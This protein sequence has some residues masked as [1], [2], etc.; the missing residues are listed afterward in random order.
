M[1]MMTIKD[2]NDLTSIANCLDAKGL[3]KE[4]DLLD[5]VMLKISG[6]LDALK[7]FLDND[8]KDTGDDKEAAWAAFEDEWAEIEAE[9]AE[10]T[11]TPLSAEEK[12][13]I[14]EKAL[15][16]HGRP[17]ALEDKPDEPESE[18]ARPAQLRDLLDERFPLDERKRLANM[19]LKDYQHNYYISDIGM[20][21]GYEYA[22]I[23]G[24]TPINTATGATYHTP[25]WSGKKEWRAG[26][27]FVNFGDVSEIDLE[28]QLLTVISDL[29]GIN[30]IVL[31]TG[32]RTKSLPNVIH[33][34][35][36]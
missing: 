1:N 6:R 35:T 30:D 23:S 29:P 28:E 2:V 36:N 3:T 20:K 15:A 12:A 9:V 33:P 17:S 11:K 31:S 26:D 8:G 27:R 18:T 14:R 21:D 10:E 7:E 13:S 34:N 32:E 19:M 4:A 16:E 5:Q 22:V 25:D 24:S